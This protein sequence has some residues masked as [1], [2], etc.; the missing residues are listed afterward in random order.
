MYLK[1]DIYLRSKHK[2]LKG[3]LRFDN[4]L[5]FLLYTVYNILYYVI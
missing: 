4:L 2:A 5:I 1:N 3:L